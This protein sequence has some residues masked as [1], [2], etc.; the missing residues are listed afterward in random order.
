MAAHSKVTD[1]GDFYRK[2]G[3]QRERE[4]IVE[5][6]GTVDTELG[7]QA[8][9]SDDDNERNALAGAHELTLTLVR[10]LTKP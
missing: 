4:R 10:E 7:R 6:L 9:A 8:A 2:Q 3:A 5:W 1:L